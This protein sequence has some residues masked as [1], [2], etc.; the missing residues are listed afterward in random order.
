[1]TPSG[2]CVRQ[3]QRHRLFRR[4]RSACL[5]WLPLAAT[6]PCGEAHL[7]V[8]CIQTRFQTCRGLRQ[9]SGNLADHGLPSM[10]WWLLARLGVPATQASNWVAP[11][12]CQ[13]G[14]LAWFRSVT[15]IKAIMV[16]LKMQLLY[17]EYNVQLCSH[18]PICD[19]S[20]VG[21]PSCDTAP[22]EVRAARGQVL[23]SLVRW[24]ECF[25]FSYR[26]LVCTP[27]LLVFLLALAVASGCHQF[28]HFMDAMLM[29]KA[30]RAK[31]VAL[32]AARF[33]EGCAGP[34]GLRNA[35]PASTTSLLAS[36][37]LL[38]PCTIELLSASPR[39]HHDPCGDGDDKPLA[40]HRGLLDLGCASSDASMSLPAV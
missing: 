9:K 12:R 28:E 20:S 11:Q 25:I 34:S 6:S 10:Q 33:L 21:L 13:A 3:R 36:L 8:K 35:E 29:T 26:I 31:L 38:M 27:A 32:E 1:M 39:G 30:A 2:P 5:L 16:L 17:C 23:S 4:C 14:P 7:C 22:T 24:P 19:C 37:L 18:P 40:M 15:L